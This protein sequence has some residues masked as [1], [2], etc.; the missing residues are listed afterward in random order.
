MEISR[1]LEAFRDNRQLHRDHMKELLNT[2]FKKHVILP[3]WDKE[4]RFHQRV[5]FDLAKE[6]D[7]IGWY[8][9][10]VWAKIFDTAIEKKKIN[11]LHDFRLVHGLMHKLNTANRESH[12]SHLNGKF[13]TQIGKLLEKHYTPDRLWKYNS[14][15]RELR[16]LQELIE[17][18]EDARMED[19]I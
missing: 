1:L 15:T 13:D 2:H 19:H 7:F 5:L 10:E 8:D 11:N 4:V 17:R 14:E 6:L 16:S 3:F 9:E 12:A 18:R